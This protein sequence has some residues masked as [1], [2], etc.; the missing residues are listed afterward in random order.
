V[1]GNVLGL[2]LLRSPI[3]PDPLADEGEQS[4]TYALMPHGGD[5]FAAGVL[6]EAEDLNQPL[7]ATTAHGLQVGEVTPVRLSGHG[8]ALAGL[9]PAEDTADVVLRVYEPVGG[10]GGLEVSLASGWSVAGD[11]NLLEE[12]VERTGDFG[13]RPFEVRSLRLAR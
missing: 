4:F 7:L 13:I 10:R 6:R 11:V 1:R 12:A 9:K 3:Y 2:S 8:V 5:W